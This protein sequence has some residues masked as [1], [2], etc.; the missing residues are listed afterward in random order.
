MA[1]RAV[2]ARGFFVERLDR[3]QVMVGGLADRIELGKG[4]RYR[5]HGFLHRRV[6]EIPAAQ[7]HPRHER[8]LVTLQFRIGPADTE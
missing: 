5:Q 4:I 2:E 1:D 7:F 6:E 3:V 8:P